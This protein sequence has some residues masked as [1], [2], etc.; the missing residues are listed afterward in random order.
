[1]LN[2]PELDCN[3]RSYFWI[4]QLASVLNDK[5]QK[6]LNT[7]AGLKWQSI[8]NFDLRSGKTTRRI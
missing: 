2:V 1:M 3:C 4:A 8:R 5:E 6:Q 7:D